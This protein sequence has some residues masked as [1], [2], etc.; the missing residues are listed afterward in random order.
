MKEHLSLRPTL[1]WD[2]NIK[3]LDEK[4][5]AEFIVGRVLDLG[6]LKEWKAIKDFYGL[7]KIKKTISKHIFSDPRS[8]N[9]WAMIF[10]INLKNLR[11]RK[12]FSLKTPR[13]FSMR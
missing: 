4:E 5:D 12:M 13:A 1:F 10:G 9:F 2:V 6:N 7:T 11:C 3:K 8:L